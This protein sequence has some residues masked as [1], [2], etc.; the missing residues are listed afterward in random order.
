M[1]LFSKGSLEKLTWDQVRQDVIR[2]NPKLA[3]I[4]DEIA[5]SNAYWI[6]K[7]TYPYGSLVMEK[8]VLMLPNREGSI[9]PITDSSLETEF[10][11]G[12]G[13]NLQSNPVS[14]VLNNSFEIFLP[15]EDRTIPLSGLILPGTVFGA[16]RILS[17]KK[18]EQT[19]FIWNMTAG[20]RS[21]FMLPKITESK[22]HAQLKKA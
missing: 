20:A 5:P 18:A 9:V 4:I 3:N 17:S 22:K 1:T 2:V 10:Q 12:L 19:A 8:S 21:V 14:I 15:L 6:A 7:A 13:Y 16:W 11:E